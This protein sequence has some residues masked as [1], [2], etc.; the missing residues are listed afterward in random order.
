MI[1]LETILTTLNLK[2]VNVGVFVTIANWKMKTPI[3]HDGFEN[4]GN[5]IVIIISTG[6]SMLAFILPLPFGGDNNALNTKELPAP[7]HIFMT[8]LDL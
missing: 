4:Y 6:I 7:S 8:S 1:I 2:Y 3:S 5:L